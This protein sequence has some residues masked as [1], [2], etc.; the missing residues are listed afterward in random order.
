MTDGEQ[1]ADDQDAGERR[2]IGEEG[3]HLAAPSAR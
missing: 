2:E 3:G 1:G